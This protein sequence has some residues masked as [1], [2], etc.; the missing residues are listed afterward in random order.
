MN[1]QLQPIFARQSE[2]PGHWYGPDGTPRYTVIGANGRERH[3]TLADARKNG[4]FPS[5]TQIQKVKAAPQL[6]NWM[7]E[8]SILAALTLPRI[9]GETERDYVARVKEDGQAQ[10]KAAAEEG[11][12][13]HNALELAFDHQSIGCPP[14]YLSHLAGVMGCIFEHFPG[15]T[16]WVSEASFAHPLGYG[17]KVDL[18]SP[19]TGI[20]IDY[21]GKDC[22][23]GDVDSK[24]KPK[25]YGYPNHCEQLAAYQTGLNLPKA[26][27]A[28]I[29]VSRTHPGHCVLQVWTPDD[30]AHGWAMFER[31]LSL[32]Q[33]DNR[34]AA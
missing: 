12:R 10:A 18:H 6:T 2:Q 24:G 28:N 14:Q 29:F 34:L 3:T 7:V 27:C 21:K 11:T 33:C 8:Q 4:W 31:M 5:V 15:V 19:S 17:G 20:V 25:T 30:I 23:P 26:P 22:A 1:A 32:W 9:D 16:D 13:I